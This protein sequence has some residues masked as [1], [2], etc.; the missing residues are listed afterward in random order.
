MIEDPALAIVVD[1]KMTMSAGKVEIGVFRTYTNDYAEKLKTTQEIAGVSS[2]PAEKFQDF[3]LHAHKY[4]KVEH[5]FFKTGMDTDLLDRL[6]NEY[7]L[8]TLS[9]SPLLVNQATICQTLV[10]VVQKLKALNFADGSGQ[11]RSNYRGGPRNEARQQAFGGGRTD[12]VRLRKGMK[13]LEP[14][15]ASF[16]E[17][18]GQVN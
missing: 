13:E 16:Q 18:T 8:H 14:I 3:G 2:M 12:K 7:W 15:Q 5:S 6:W 1:P 10:N 9:H 17:V 11:G 4:Y